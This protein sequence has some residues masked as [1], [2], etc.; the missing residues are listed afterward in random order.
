MAT[1][2]S[3]K[4][5]LSEQVIRDPVL[6]LVFEFI[7]VPGSVDP[8]RIVVRDFAGNELRELRFNKGGDNSGGSAKPDA[9]AAQPR[10][11]RVK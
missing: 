6:N 9:P 3:R 4:L 5:T 10:L 2:Q 11:R 7:T 1:D 8:Y